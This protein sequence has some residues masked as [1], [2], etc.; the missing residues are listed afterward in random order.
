[1]NDINDMRIGFI[2]AGKVGVTLGAYFKENGRRVVG[3]ASRL[4]SDAKEAA[5]ITGTHAYSSIS[6]LV[7]D[8]DMIWISTQDGQIASV[9]NALRKS[10]IAG[11]IICHTSG[12]VS[13]DVFAGISERGVWGYSVHPMFAFA[14]RSGKTNGFKRYLFY[15]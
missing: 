5:K 11:R 2:G 14:D 9:W 13:S 3:Y 6:Q 7:A 12:S 15:H 1:M 10:D 8:C 4:F